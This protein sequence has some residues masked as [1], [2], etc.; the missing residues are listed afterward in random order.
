MTFPELVEELIADSNVR[1]DYFVN[2]GIQPPPDDQELTCPNR[3]VLT[4]RS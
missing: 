3:T 1:R 2:A 4:G